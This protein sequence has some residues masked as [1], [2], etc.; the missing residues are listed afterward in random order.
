MVLP[1][2]AMHLR[3]WLAREER[4]VFKTSYAISAYYAGCGQNRRWR[5]LP[6]H[7]V[8]DTCSSIWYNGRQKERRSNAER[9][10]SRS[11]TP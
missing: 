4:L 9:V 8:R 7:P 1:S 5:W 6:D 3:A 2:A 10:Q 11:G